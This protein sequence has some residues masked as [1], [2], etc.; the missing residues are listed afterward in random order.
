MSHTLHKGSIATRIKRFLV[1]NPS[2]ELTMGDI[3]IKFDT[4]RTGAVNAVIRLKE[5]GI[6]YAK[7]VRLKAKGVAS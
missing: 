4:T 6:E 2:E 5:H 1:D 7:V 3:E